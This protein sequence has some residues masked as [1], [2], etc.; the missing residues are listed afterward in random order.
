MTTSDNTCDIAEEITWGKSLVEMPAVTIK[1]IEAHRVNSGKS[2]GGAIIKTLERGRKFK[3]ERYIT[4]DSIF[5]AVQGQ[6][7]LVKATCKASMKNELCQVKLSLCMVTAH[8]IDS[9]CSCPAGLSGYCNHVMALLFELADYSLNQLCE[10]PEEIACTSKLRQW[11]IPGK[12]SNAKEPVMN[13]TIHKQYDKKG[14]SCTLYD[15]RIND[16]RQNAAWRFQDLALKL[17]EKDLR[18]GF[19][20]SD[21]TQTAMKNTKYGEFVIGSP[22]S[23]QLAPTESNIKFITNIP[24]N[25]NVSYSNLLY[26]NLPLIFHSEE[27]E[28]YPRDWL[29]NEQEIMFLKTLS[30]S[31]D[32][33]YQGLL[34]TWTSN[35]Q[36]T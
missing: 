2:T 1:E 12:S 25:D 4:A 18:I 34:Y 36:T 24:S 29:F 7:F 22:L 11:G 17:K 28:A 30:V 15:P 13:L 33:S 27:H 6:A 31:P 35:S 32:D 16:S 3:E 9:T 10:V 21:P 26:M 14:I 19:A 23:F 5:T 20:H 8:V